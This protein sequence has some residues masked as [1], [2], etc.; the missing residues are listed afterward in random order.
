MA[1]GN[2]FVWKQDDPL[3]WLGESE[4]MPTRITFR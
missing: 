1:G 2:R 4:T 3:A